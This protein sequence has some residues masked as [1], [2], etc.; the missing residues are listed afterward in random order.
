[1]E[2]PREASHAQG[3]C[4]GKTPFVR[5]TL[6]AIKPDMDNSAKHIAAKSVNAGAGHIVGLDLVRFIA[7][8][9]VVLFHYFAWSWLA[10][11]STVGRVLHD[12]IVAFPGESAWTWFGWI[13]VEVF[14][15]ISGFVIAFSA[16]T[17]SAGSFA[18]ARILRLAP[19]AWICACVTLAVALLI[20]FDYRPALAADF[21]R[22]VLFSPVGPYIDGVYWTLG[23]EVAFYFL[24]FLLLRFST[25]AFIERLAIALGLYSASFLFASLFVPNIVTDL[26]SRLIEIS[27]LRHGVYFALGVMIWACARRGP[28]L[29]RLAFCALLLAAG[30]REIELTAA[31]FLSEMHTSGNVIIP[32]IAFTVAVAMIA[33][34]VFANRWLLA[35]PL[36]TPLRM[37]GLATYPLYLIHQLVGAEVM[38]LLIGAGMSDPAAA[39]TTIAACVA[40]AI[41]IATVLEPPLR[42]VLRGSI[43]LAQTKFAPAAS[44]V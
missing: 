7:A 22:S 30:F 34:S 21:I 26:P 6:G 33:L 24:V 11:L 19:A 36:T 40:A 8:F 41:F 43:N 42:R 25:F 29:A 5:E 23:V 32:Q 27:L 1:M 35:G 13:G 31:N 9:S 15:V 39:W 16:E 4:G 18:R 12:N 17:A 10:P 44:Q 28:S 20:R 2:A 37:L 14:F 38:K 3:V